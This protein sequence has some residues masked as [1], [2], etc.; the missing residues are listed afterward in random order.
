[1]PTEFN[2]PN[3]RS[4]T[5]PIR[6]H[7]QTIAKKM[8]EEYRSGDA[9]VVFDGK[10]DSHR[11]FIEGFQTEIQSYLDAAAVEIKHVTSLSQLEG[12]LLFD[13]GTTLI[14]TGVTKR[15]QLHKLIYCHLDSKVADGQSIRLFGHPLWTRYDSLS[16]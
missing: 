12:P 6:I 16:L 3:L 8:A 13:E 2:I 1:M 9:I 7:L 11:Q 14:I 5:P 4:I 15:A 10:D